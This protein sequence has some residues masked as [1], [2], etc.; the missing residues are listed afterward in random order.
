M[1]RYQN[2][3]SYEVVYGLW[4]LEVIVLQNSLRLP[5][6]IIEHNY[7]LRDNQTSYFK[8]CMFDLLIDINYLCSVNINLMIIMVL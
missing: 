6:L 7:K 1:H 2:C 3:G 8:I 5:S 4:F